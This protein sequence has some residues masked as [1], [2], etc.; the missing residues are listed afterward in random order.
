MSGSVWVRLKQSACV[1]TFLV[2]GLAFGLSKK[3]TAFE[4]ARELSQAK[5]VTMRI[6][7]REVG[8]ARSKGAGADLGARAAPN[9]AP[10]CSS[11]AWSSAGPDLPR[12]LVLKS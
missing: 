2:T 8:E 11:R 6:N 4:S 7:Q 9:P 5:D 12:G 3:R 1:V 10:G